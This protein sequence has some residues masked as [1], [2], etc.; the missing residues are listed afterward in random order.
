M[1]QT[2]SQS[3]CVSRGPIALSITPRSTQIER[4]LRR[5]RADGEDD[6]DGE[7]HL[8]RPQEAEQARERAAICGSVR[9]L[10]P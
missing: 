6:R 2:K 3:F 8:V 4:D 10:H 5:L 9:L 1:S 7:R